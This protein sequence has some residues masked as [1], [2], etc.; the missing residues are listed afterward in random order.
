MSEPSAEVYIDLT[1]IGPD[2]IIDRGGRAWGDFASALAREIN[3]AF[4][5]A[6]DKSLKVRAQ[7]VD[8]RPASSKSPDAGLLVGGVLVSV[9]ASHGYSITAEKATRLLK[10]V[11]QSLKKLL[12]TK[13][14]VK[15]TS[16]KITID[17]DADSG[18]SARFLL[19]A[20]AEVVS[21]LSAKQENRQDK[22][23][24]AVTLKPRKR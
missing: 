21:T 10:E 9:L 18:D 13:T 1:E 12:P 7:T 17:I 2:L 15:I 16:G 14:H 11:W 8:T 5:N 3:G 24:R 23:K 20:G 4:R 19:Q 6:E 22:S